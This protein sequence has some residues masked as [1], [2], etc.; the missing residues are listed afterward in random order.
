MS[1]EMN[2]QLAKIPADD[3]K[4]SGALQFSKI[5]INEDYC[6]KWNV[7]PKDFICLTRNG[8]LL[9]PT[10]YRIGGLN[11]PKLN[12]DEYF[13]LIKHVEAYYSKDIMKGSKSQD[14]KHLDGWWCI[15][16]KHGNEKVVFEPAKYPLT[17]PYLVADSC[18]YSIGGKYHNIETG[19]FYCD[20]SS[21]MT[22]ADFL[23]LEN[24][25]DKDK[26]RRGVMKIN[27][28]SGLWELFP[29]L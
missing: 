6:K 27:K 16:D 18:I 17:Y 21:S 29:S 15:L 23:F 11:T 9:R 7:R 19:E 8:E 2:I 12:K 20:T 25:F 14:P 28:K 13:M 10:L 3:Q 24:R 26:S 1:E 22:S 4:A 5:D